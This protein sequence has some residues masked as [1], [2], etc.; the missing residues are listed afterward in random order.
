[1][2]VTE[3]GD[4]QVADEFLPMIHTAFANLKTWI[5]GIHHGVSDQHLQAGGSNNSAFSGIIGPV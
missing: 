4:P 5:N 1:M 2:H 3:R